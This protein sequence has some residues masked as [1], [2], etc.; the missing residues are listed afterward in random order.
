MDLV[1]IGTYI[2]SKRKALGLTQKQVAEKLG[3]SDKSVS[4]WERGIC[5]PDVSVY[6]ELCEILGIT[7]NEFLAGEDI[8]RADLPAKSE[9]NLI[10]VTQDSQHRQRKLKRVIATLVALTLLVGGCLGVV[11]YGHFSQPQNYIQALDQNSP[12][13]TTAE[14]LSQN[15]GAMLFRFHA[16]KPYH[17]LTVYQYE[18]RSGELVAKTAVADFFYADQTAWSDGML[19]FILDFDASRVRLVVANDGT[20]HTKELP[21]LEGVEDITSYIRGSTQVEGTL[22]IADDAEQG[23][24]ALGYGK[25]RLAP[26]SMEQLAQGNAEP[27]MDY[28]YYFSVEFSLSSIPPSTDC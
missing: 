26:L 23:L 14:L 4:K 18:Y 10:Q 15:D 27:S 20:T 19:A 13:V 6:L 3:M 5:L 25:W 28:A 21:I 11:L 24:L 16:K 12:E 2:A 17:Q 22:P 8:P 9:D 1:K 7:I